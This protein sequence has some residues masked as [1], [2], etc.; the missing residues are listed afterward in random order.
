MKIKAIYVHLPVKD[1]AKTRAFWTQLGFIFNDH[2]SNDRALCLVL[3]EDRMYSMLISHELFGTFTHK[4]IADGSTTQVLAAL[5]V[6]SREEV[7]RI[8]QGALQHGGTRYREAVDHDWMYY[9]SFADLD[10]HQWEVMYTDTSK[11]TL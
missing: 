4:P 7:D 9:D 3:Q 8:V 2:F 5:E 10:G 11:L 1:L 6:E